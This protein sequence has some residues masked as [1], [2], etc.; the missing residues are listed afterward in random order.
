ML[1]VMRKIR[2]KMMTVAMRM[3]DENDDRDDIHRASLVAQW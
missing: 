1:K 2:V 3:M